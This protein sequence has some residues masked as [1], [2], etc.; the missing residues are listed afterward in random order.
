[1]QN[2]LDKILP[3]VDMDTKQE[4]LDLLNDNKQY[5]QDLNFRTLMKIISMR[6]DPDNAEDWHDMAI[7]AMT[8][9]VN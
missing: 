4:C 9:T 8:C 1:M 5:C 2:I 7:Y 3:D 6:T